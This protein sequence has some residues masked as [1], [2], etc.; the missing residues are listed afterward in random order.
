[1]DTK[2]ST[3]KAS[4]QELKSIGLI[5]NGNEQ[6]MKKEIENK[7]GCTNKRYLETE[8]DDKIF[9]PP[10]KKRKLNQDNNKNATTT[11]KEKQQ[12]DSKLL[13]DGLHDCYYQILMDKVREIQTT[14]N[15]LTN[16]AES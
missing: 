7:D 14:I 11:G 10:S 2:C 16:S 1:M 12:C 4:K 8:G 9:S 13:Q 5:Q 3:E 15:S 6:E